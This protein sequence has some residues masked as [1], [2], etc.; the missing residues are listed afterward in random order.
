VRVQ[1]RNASSFLV[2]YSLNLSRGG[3]FVESEQPAQEG[4]EVTLQFDVAGHGPVVVKGRA[5]WHRPAIAP[6]Q[7]GGFGVKFEDMDDHL[8]KMIDQI[9]KSFRGM[10]VLLLCADKHDRSSI[11]GLIKSVMSAAEVTTAEHA[12][13]ALSELREEQDLVIIDADID[14][15]GCAQL[16][17]QA[18]AEGMRVPTIVLAA[19]PQTRRQALQSGATCTLP[20]PPPIAEFRRLLVEA[21]GRPETE[22]KPL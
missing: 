17:Q 18:S 12:A 3:L 7:S 8:G 5:V 11:T 4:S 1:Y 20:N 6:E 13:V 22:V 10:H 16:L 14:P 21:I 2:S 19:D 9:V 15:L